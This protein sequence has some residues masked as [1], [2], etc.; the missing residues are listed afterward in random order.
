MLDL[1]VSKLR[2]NASHVELINVMRQLRDVRERPGV[3]VVCALEDQDGNPGD[4]GQLP[5][6]RAFCRR[7]VDIG[8]ISWLEP[9][10]RV[11]CLIPGPVQQAYPEIGT[12]LGAWEVW[13]IAE[14][15]S[16]RPA[17]IDNAP[18]VE[19]LGWMQA[20]LAKANQRSDKAL[21]GQEAP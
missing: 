2:T 5:E 4:L 11:S 18:V 14:G 3:V 8:F 20:E 17:G 7:L 6:V 9:T 12:Y 16:K 1:V 13:A 19:V 15:L 21:A 10:T